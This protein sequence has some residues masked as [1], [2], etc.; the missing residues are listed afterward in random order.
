MAALLSGRMAESLNKWGWYVDLPPFLKGSLGETGIWLSVP[1]AWLLGAIFS[2]FY[3]R[4]GRWK[5]KSV[6]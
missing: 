3:Y 2:Y 4:T 1:I 5:T 6:L